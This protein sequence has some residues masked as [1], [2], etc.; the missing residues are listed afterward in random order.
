MT[1]MNPQRVSRGGVRISATSG[2][3]KAKHE[4]FPYRWGFDT[5]LLREMG[6][7]SRGR[8]RWPEVQRVQRDM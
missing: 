4:V 5:L 6:H 8:R 3:E 7:F 2:D 1:L